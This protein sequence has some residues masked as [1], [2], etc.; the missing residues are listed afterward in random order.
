LI[1]LKI[2]EIAKAND[3][4]FVES[5]ALARSIFHTTELEEEVPEGLYVAVAQVLAYVFQLRQFRRGQG[6]R[7]YYVANPNIPPDMRY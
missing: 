7:P 5:P 2:R 1:A 3:I 4:E 6:T